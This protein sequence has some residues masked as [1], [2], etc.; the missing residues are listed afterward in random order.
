MN[1]KQ[2]VDNIAKIQVRPFVAPVTP[3]TQ[4]IFIVEGGRNQ[5]SVSIPDGLATPRYR[6]YGRL[7]RQQSR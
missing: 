3:R 2:L 1:A 5:S 6:P 4:K 7:L